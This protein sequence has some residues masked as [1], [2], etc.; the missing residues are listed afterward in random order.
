MD[1]KV[2]PFIAGMVRPRLE[3]A[4]QFIAQMLGQLRYES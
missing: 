4:V 2:N 3:E 1:A